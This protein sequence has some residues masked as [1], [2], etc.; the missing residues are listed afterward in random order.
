MFFFYFVFRVSTIFDKINERNAQRFLKVLIETE[1]LAY[2]YLSFSI[3]PKKV[4]R[5]KTMASEVKLSE[6]ARDENRVKSQ[7]NV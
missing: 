1:F 2:S 7:K 6:V 4:G 3:A 5:Q